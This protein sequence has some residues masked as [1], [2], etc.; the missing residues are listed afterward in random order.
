MEFKGLGISLLSVCLIFHPQPHLA[1]SL[2][3]GLPVTV[4]WSAE[5]MVVTATASITMRLGR[6]G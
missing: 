5:A 1:H 4:G 3:A 2:Y 6:A